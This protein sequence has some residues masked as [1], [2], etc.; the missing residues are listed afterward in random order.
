[1]KENEEGRKE[2]LARYL[3]ALESGELASYEADLLARACLDWD[4][5][6]D[7]SRYAYLAGYYQGLL[8]EAVSRKRGSERGE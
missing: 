7:T 6:N 4:G 1:L 2:K 3:D 8:N 5:D